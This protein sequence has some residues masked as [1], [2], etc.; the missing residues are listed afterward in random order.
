VNYQ[1]IQSILHDLV[2]SGAGVKSAALVSRDGLPMAC[3]RMNDLDRDRIAAM[4]AG[5]MTMGSRSA[6]EFSL[7][8]LK[9]VIL[10]CDDGYAIIQAAKDAVLCAIADASMPLGMPLSRA[11]EV[12]KKLAEKL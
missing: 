2:E 12:S 7:K 10:S 3:E 6:L 8:N 4:V 9:Q 5:L 1:E 11:S